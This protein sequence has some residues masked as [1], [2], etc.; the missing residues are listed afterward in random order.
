M[1]KQPTS[2][3]HLR[4]KLQEC[5][6]ELTEPYL[7]SVVER[8]PRFCSAVITARGDYFRLTKDMTNI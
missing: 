5:C 1:A 7:M 3:S 6:G 2:A 8:M 4:K